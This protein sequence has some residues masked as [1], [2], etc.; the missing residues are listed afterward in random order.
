MAMPMVRV[1][2]VFSEW[3]MI[4]VS[5]ADCSVR[6]RA[7]IF[8]RCASTMI[9]FWTAMY[10]FCASTKH[11]MIAVCSFWRTVEWELEVREG[12]KVTEG[13]EDGVLSSCAVSMETVS[14]CRVVL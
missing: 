11:L 5:S 1:G 14:S 12:W 3:R 8:V 13:R 6:W 7:A 4:A 10:S 2:A 9:E